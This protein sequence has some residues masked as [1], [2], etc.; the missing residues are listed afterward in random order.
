M[1][2]PVY[3]GTMQSGRLKADAFLQALRGFNG[4]VRLTVEKDSGKRSSQANRY[5]WGVVVEL[6]SR[7]LKEVGWEPAAC[8]PKAVHLDLRRRFLTEEKHVKDGLFM[9]H[10]KSTTELDS[11]A[12][13]EYLEHCIRFAAEWLGVAIPPPG[14]QQEM[15]YEDAA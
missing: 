7:G 13:G 5:Y 11:E 12:F 1:S 9:E 14:E 4:P 10:V 6:I 3:Y 2:A 8:T 15:E